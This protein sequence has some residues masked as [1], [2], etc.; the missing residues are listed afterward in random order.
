MANN[1]IQIVIKA[2]GSSAMKTIGEVT[3]GLGGIGGKAASAA[4]AGIGVT[5]AAIAG[6]GAAG[7]ASFIGFEQQMNEVFTLLPGITEQTMGEMTEQV[8]AFSKEFGTLPEEVIPA[9]YQ[10]LSSG[11]PQDTVFDFLEIAQKAAIGGV[12]NV[13][14]AVSGISSVVNAYGA[15]VINA[16]EASDLMFTAAAAGVTTFD[17]LSKSLYNV[18]P[19]AAALGVQFGD[20]M[21][22]MASMTLQGTPT[23]VATTQL[24]Q[25]FVELSQDGGAASDMFKELSGTTFKD[26]I[27]SGG[28]VQDAL[29]LMEAAAKSNGVGINDLFSSVEAG[30]AALALTGKGTQSFTDSLEKMAAST[31]ATDAAYKRMNEGIGR[32]LDKIKAAAK[33]FLIDIGD[34]LA[35]TFS[36]FADAAIGAFAPL[37][38]FVLGVFDKITPVIDEFTTYIGTLF[39]AFNAGGVAGLADALGLTPETMELI[40]KIT[41]DLQALATAATA[42]FGVAMAWLSANVIPAINVAIAFLNEHWEAFRNALIAIIAVIAGATVFTTIAATIAMIANPVTL[43]IAAVGLLAA[44]WTENWGGIRDILTNFWTNTAQPM[45]ATLWDWLSVNIPI[46]LQTLSTFW[47]TV[48]QP[49]L[50]AVWGFIQTSVIPALSTLWGWLAENVPAALQTLSDFW[51]GTLLPAITEVWK[52]IQSNILPIFATLGNWLGVA[53]KSDVE[54]LANVWQNLLL[55]AITIVWDFIQNSIIP[56]FNT[57]EQLI[58]T[59]LNVAVSVL[60]DLWQN[61][62]QPAL[63]AVWNFITASLQPVLDALATAFGTI[64]DAVEKVV[65]VLGDTFQPVLQTISDFI[66]NTVVPAFNPFAIVVGAIKGAFDGMKTAIDFVIGALQNLIDLI[67]DMPDIP[68]TS[69]VSSALSALSGANGTLN[70]TGAS[71]E[72][73]S[74]ASSSTVYNFN[75]TVNTKAETST[76]VQDFQMMR[77]LIA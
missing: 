74:G 36:R 39:D 11:V 75:Q 52:F 40:G 10:A 66:T 15:D 9:L 61:S 34:R 32:S 68:G 20:V 77:A 73:S 26:F 48:L 63:T 70:I 42:Q 51:Q 56:L 28:N 58:T 69:S 41:T 45:L 33:V 19:V 57:L 25:L 43:V 29:Q 4:V 62:L 1:T 49:A 21:A 46:A 22:A 6:F 55:P 13:E 54:M 50:A 23:S 44:A 30:S 24:R 27:A 12:T 67:E 17:E 18:N 8:K 53:L 7:I 5:T 71:S 16:G 60:A 59:V 31:G 2:D 64:K 37:S 3:D 38:A 35:P 47:T 14:A 72:G 76:V 65:D